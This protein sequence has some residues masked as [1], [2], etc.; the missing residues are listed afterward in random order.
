[1]KLHTKIQLLKFCSTLLNF[2]FLALG[3][4]VAGCGLW[5][6]FDRSFISVA[7]SSSDVL[8]VVAVAL[9]AVGGLVLVV[10]VFGCVGAQRESRV[11]LLPVGVILVL[12]VL[13]QI[14]ITLLLLITEDEISTQTMN[15]VDERIQQYSPKKPLLLDNLQHYAKCCGLKAP[16]D[17]L[18]NDYL[19]SLNL[20]EVLPCSCFKGNR[21]ESGAFC[22]NNLTVTSE[23]IQYGNI[24]YSQGC[25]TA[26]QEWMNENL[27]TIIGMNLGL[28]LV[29]VAQLV[30]LVNL[31]RSFRAKS[32]VKSCEPDQDQDQVYSDQEQLHQDLDQELHHG[33][34]DGPY[35]EPYEGQYQDPDQ[36]YS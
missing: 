31:Y 2:I 8:Q 36:D 35:G 27:W 17:W 5:I 32:S 34:Y 3:L 22:S 16:S 14:F 7:S 21:Y 26:L 9:L 24:S 13:A 15:A 30:V 25:E 29:Q 12:L 33:A 6:L 18:K 11:L 4:S 20:S 1:M 28:L 19:Q 10:S 23:T